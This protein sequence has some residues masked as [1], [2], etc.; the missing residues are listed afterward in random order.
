MSSTANETEL[1]SDNRPADA[2]SAQPADQDLLSASEGNNGTAEVVEGLELVPVPE[3]PTWLAFEEANEYA[4]LFYNMTYDCAEWDYDLPSL[5]KEFGNPLEKSIEYCYCDDEDDHTCWLKREFCGTRG[6]H[7]RRRRKL[8]DALGQAVDGLESGLL[9]IY[10]WSTIRDDSDPG[11]AARQAAR[12]TPGLHKVATSH[13]STLTNGVKRLQEFHKRRVEVGSDGS[14][15]AATT[16]DGGLHGKAGRESSDDGGSVNEDSDE[17]IYDDDSDENASD[18]A[19]D[20]DTS[21]ESDEDLA[22]LRRRLVACKAEF[23]KPLRG[24]PDT[25]AA[26][27]KATADLKLAVRTYDNPTAGP[28]STIREFYMACV[29]QVADSMPSLKHYDEH[30][31]CDG[32]YCDLE[33][34][35][36]RYRKAREDLDI[37]YASAEMSDGLSKILRS[38]WDETRSHFEDSGLPSLLERP[39]DLDRDSDM[40]SS[41]TDQEDSD[42]EAEEV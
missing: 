9:P 2:P 5:L 30:P 4:Q 24:L 12:L 22:G 33:N 14:K 32:L 35:D 7:G 29:L 17:D 1:S 18:N 27:M 38:I 23:L 11:V 3:K 16:C 28:R 21:D 37:F 20:E 26:I 36:K 39:D 15:S 25:K 6:K 19:S 13:L 42:D 40:E 31:I 41:C 34:I 8:V 10:R